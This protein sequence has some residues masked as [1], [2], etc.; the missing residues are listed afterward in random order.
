MVSPTTT[1]RLPIAIRDRLNAQARGRGMSVVALLDEWTNRAERED[2]FAAERA[3]TLAEA[4]SQ[5]AIDEDD[6]WDQIDTDDL[7]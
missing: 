4:A 2:A 7:D 6:D 1:I 5:A 3:A